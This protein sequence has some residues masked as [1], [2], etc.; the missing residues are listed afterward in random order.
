MSDYDILEKN[1]QCRY[2]GVKVIPRSCYAFG[3]KDYMDDYYYFE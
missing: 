2:C 3:A 1:Y